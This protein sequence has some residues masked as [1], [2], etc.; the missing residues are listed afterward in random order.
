MYVLHASMSFPSSIQL[1]LSPPPTR[2][3]S[4]VISQVFIRVPC[5]PHMGW[6]LA[7]VSEQTKGRWSQGAVLLAERDEIIC[8]NNKTRTKLCSGFKDAAYCGD[9]KGRSWIRGLRKA[10][11][12]AAG[13]SGRTGMVKVGIPK[14]LRFASLMR[15]GSDL[16][17]VC[18]TGISWT[19]ALQRPSAGAQ[20]TCQRNSKE[21]GK[22]EMG[23]RAGDHDREAS[24]ADHRSLG[25]VLSCNCHALNYIL[26]GPFWLTWEKRSEGSQTRIGRRPGYHLR[27]HFRAVVLNLGSISESPGQ[28]YKPEAWATKH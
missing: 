2:W 16:S 11:C 5:V 21:V 17:S 12:T 23:W 9:K 14:R 28:L 18:R 24:G 8:N 22:A 1:Y 15:R 10:G 3:P 6:E 26:R 7:V 25:K 4:L 27:G 13:R 20:M 19:L